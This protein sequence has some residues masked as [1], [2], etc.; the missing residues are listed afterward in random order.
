MQ[1]QVNTD[2]NIK[3]HV[4]LIRLVEAEVRH[5]LSR[6]A[7]QIM[8]VEVHLTDENGAKHGR[9]DKRCMMEARC[10]GRPSVA[11]SDESATIE[12]A[13]HGAAKK[14]Q[15]LLESHLGKSDAHKG[16]ELTWS[17]L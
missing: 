16:G 3:G 9:T 1:V 15:R 12:G 10:S 4:E 14:L 5:T 17:I 6:F 8:R 13:F 7:D 2:A 11:V